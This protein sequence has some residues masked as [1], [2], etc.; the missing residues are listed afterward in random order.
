MQKYDAGFAAIIGLASWLIYPIVG[1]Y[2]AVAAM[3][4]DFDVL[5]YLNAIHAM[6]FLLNLALI[7]G[8]VYLLLRILRRIASNRST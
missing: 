3:P 5:P 7:G 1:Y 6:A 4:N 8:W 2:A